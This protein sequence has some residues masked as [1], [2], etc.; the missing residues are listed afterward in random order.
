MSF[1]SPEMQAR[2]TKRVELEADLRNAM[3]EQEFILYYQPQVDIVG[4]VVGVEALVRWNN[5]VRGLVSPAEFVPVAEDIGLIFSLGEWVMKTA[6]VRLAKWSRD[7]RTKMLTMAV[8]V[9]APQFHHPD[10]IKQVLGV[11]QETGVDPTRLKLELTESLL[12][13]DIEGTI[14]K[15]KALKHYGILFSLDDFGTGY[16][17]LTYLHRLP[18]DQLKIDQSFIRDALSDENAAVIVRTV[19]A[20]G[21]AL[22]LAV[23]AEGVETSAHHVFISDE[24]CTEFQGYL[25]SKPLPEDKLEEYLLTARI[26]SQPQRPQRVT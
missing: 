11:V 16:S 2:I 9:S 12:V 15:M 3:R 17:S 23:I 25:F 10:F 13:E 5:P 14:K 20:L 1:F 6:C 19:L 4:E 18:L 8:N 22:K 21:Q 26:R 24:G 7:A